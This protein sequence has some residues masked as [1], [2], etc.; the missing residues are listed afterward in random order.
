[1]GLFNNNGAD[2]RQKYRWHLQQILREKHGA[3]EI[4]SIDYTKAMRASE[5]N[6][7]IEHCIAESRKSGT[8]GSNLVG[9]FSWAGIWEWIKENW[10]EILKVIITI[11]ILFAD[12]QEEKEFYGDGL[13]GTYG[14]KDNEEIC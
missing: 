2:H 5:R 9:E 1:M 12:T 10:F 7:V 11:A 3:G 14:P 13:S 8:D 4:A 6:S